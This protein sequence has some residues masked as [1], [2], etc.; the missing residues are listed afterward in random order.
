MK[1]LLG[2]F[3]A[4]LRRQDIFKLT[5]ANESLPEDSNDNGVGVVNFATSKNLVVK[6]TMFPHQNIYKFTWTSPDWKTHS[7]IDQVLIDRRWHSS[8]LDV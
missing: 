4:K 8:I 5:N 3:N 6:S 7:Q 2:D 1:I